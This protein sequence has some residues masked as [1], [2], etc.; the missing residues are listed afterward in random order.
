MNG[1]RTLWQLINERSLKGDQVDFGNRAMGRFCARYFFKP[2][3]RSLAVIIIISSVCGS[4]AF[5]YSWATQVIA[6]DIVQIHSGVSSEHVDR[7]PGIVSEGQVMPVVEAYI[8]PTLPGE[9]RLFSSSSYG[10]ADEQVPSGAIGLSNQLDTRYG[11]S[12][13]EQMRLLGGIAALL[14]A[15]ELA[16]HLV[17]YWVQIRIIWI[18]QAVRFRLRRH[19]YTKMMAL[20][21]IYHDRHSP[22]QLMTYLFSDIQIVIG[23]LSSLIKVVPTSILSLI[24]GVVIVFVLDSELAW[25][26][27]LAL[28][29]YVVAYRWFR[30]RLRVVNSNLRERE[31]RLNGH[32]AN[33][34]SQFLLI[35]SYHRES[36][37]T[38][39]FVRQAKPILQNHLAASILTSGFAVL[40]GVIMGICMTGVL[41]L[42]VLRVRE[43]QMTIGELLM[44]Y[45]SAG[46]LITPAT[47][48]A[49]M[50]T[51]FHKVRVRT[52]RIMHILDE[53]IMLKEP[54]V[55]VPIPHGPSALCFDNVSMQYMKGRPAALDGVSFV[56]PAGKRLC[57][58]GPS[59]SGKSTLA[60]LACRLYDPTGGHVQFDGIGVDQFA[61]PELREYVGVVSQEPLIFSGTI[62]ENIRYGSEDA[63]HKSVIAAAR[64]AQIH[65]FIEEQPL[66]YHTPTH[67]RGLALSGGQKQRVILARALLYDPKFLVLDDFTSA[68]DAL[69]EAQLVDSFKSTLRDRTT[70]IISHRI[71]I[72]LECDLVLMLDDGQVVQFGHPHTLLNKD[73]PFIDLYHEHNKRAQ[74]A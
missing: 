39:D 36:R 18:G 11:R 29:A 4:G 17:R 50:F 5:V 66:R 48:L 26:V 19:L 73:G 23:S 31:G 41:W 6:D 45:G 65:D 59:G 64:F 71:S 30:A 57:V 72:A 8:D 60:K 47:H 32:I 61:I 67:E 22:G 58:M 63:P 2:Y 33:R 68:V 69:T 10:P 43:G 1:P 20:P 3:Y 34:I 13:H 21:Q 7:L 35:K 70:L 74:T 42:G 62:G 54:A 38:A 46:Y 44:F 24:V 40:C 9:S 27:V 28:P 14:I 25:L 12:V 52:N 16:R 56:L 55:T 15:M 37:E 53:P 51:S 49:Q